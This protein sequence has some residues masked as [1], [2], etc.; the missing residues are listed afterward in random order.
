MANIHADIKVTQSNRSRHV[1]RLPRT[2]QVIHTNLL[3]LNVSAS[4]RY[5]RCRSGFHV[6]Y[7]TQPRDIFASH[8]HV[9]YFWNPRQPHHSDSQGCVITRTDAFASPSPPGSATVPIL[10]S[11]I[12]SVSSETSFSSQESFTNPH[13][14]LS[15]LVQAHPGGHASSLLADPVARCG[16]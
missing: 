12:S 8:S 10:F 3:L 13:N 4:K 11:P 14:N 2:L 9:S 5:V 7:T 6:P 16:W 1:W 15:N